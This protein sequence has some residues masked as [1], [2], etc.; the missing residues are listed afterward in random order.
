MIETSYPTMREC[1]TSVYYDMEPGDIMWVHREAE[2]EHQNDM[3]CPCCPF[4]VE[5]L[6]TDTVETFIRRGF[7]ELGN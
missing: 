5:K 3:D 6:T 7:V 2:G 4:W 1:W